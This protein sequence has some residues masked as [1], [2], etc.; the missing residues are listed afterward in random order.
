MVSADYYSPVQQNI[1]FKNITVPSF[2]DI[3]K[4]ILN[5]GKSI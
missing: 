3:I 1:I 2:Q 4:Y 5:I